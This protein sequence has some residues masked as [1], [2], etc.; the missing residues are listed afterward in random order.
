MA[1]ADRPWVRGALDGL[2]PVLAPGP[3]VGGHAVR[4][5][6][7]HHFLLLVLPGVAEKQSNSQINLNFTDG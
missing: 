5:D 3:H 4:R 7:A 6:M 2:L 1:M